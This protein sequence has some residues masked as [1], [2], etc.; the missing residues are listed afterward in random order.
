M[1]IGIDLDNTII[2]YDTSFLEAAKEAGY[3]N[4]DFCGS[5]I[6][7]R[8]VIRKQI[9]GEIK[10]QKLQG[11][12]YGKNIEKADLFVGVKRFLTRAKLR[13][14]T[15]YIVSHK[16][17]FGHFDQTKTNLHKAAER[18]LYKNGISPKLPDALVQGVFF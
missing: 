7:V 8:E 1:K 5:K 16:T 10:W 15:C 13:G 2:N 4:S 6:T 14:C 3:I 17:V 9:N 11:I 12:V 18:Y